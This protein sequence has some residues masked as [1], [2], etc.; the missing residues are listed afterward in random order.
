MSDDEN[1]ALVVITTTE[2]A[3]DGARL[4]Q[5]LVERRL[6]ACVQIIPQMTSVYRWQDKIEHASEALLFIKTTRAHYDALAAA[7]QELHSY[8][9]PEILALPVTHVAPDYLTW[10]RDA[11]KP[12]PQTSPNSLPD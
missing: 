4:A 3:S 7:I 8:E 2:T 12:L 11:L 9:T 5:Q 10:L 1:D 6:A